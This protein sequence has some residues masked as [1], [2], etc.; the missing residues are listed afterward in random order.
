ML[1]V[2]DVQEVEFEFDEQLDKYKHATGEDF[3][4]WKVVSRL[5]KG[6][7][8]LFADDGDISNGW[9]VLCPEIHQLTDVK[10]VKVWLAYSEKDDTTAMFS[11]EVED[12]AREIGAEY[13]EFNTE[14][15]ALA[16]LS[17]RFGYKPAFYTYRKEL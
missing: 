6:R 10:Y 16:R 1:K 14:F 3:D 8:F 4:N 5:Y 11:G 7:A 13:V 17:E 9:V 15:E 12:L 2:I